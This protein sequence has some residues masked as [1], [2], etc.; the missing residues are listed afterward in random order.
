MIFIKLQTQ[1]GDDVWVNPRKIV[2]IT[3]EWVGG[4]A[5]A[6]LHLG[7]RRMTTVRGTVEETLAAIEAAC[8]RG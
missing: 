4:K 5:C 2:R 3:R 6:T 1:A 7:K 8:K